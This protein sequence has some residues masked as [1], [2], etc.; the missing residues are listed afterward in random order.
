MPFFSYWQA[1]RRLTPMEL[2][3]ILFGLSGLLLLIAAADL[4]FRHLLGLPK[5][6]AFYLSVLSVAAALTIL[7]QCRWITAR[8][9]STEVEQ[10][11]AED[12]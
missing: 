10:T 9:S 12:S 8:T 5:D 11:D 4:V 7:V 6:A 1:L 2:A 3:I